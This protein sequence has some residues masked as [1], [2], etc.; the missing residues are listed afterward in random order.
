MLLTLLD[1]AQFLLEIDVERGSSHLFLY[2]EK[3][4]IRK[5]G[6][7]CEKSDDDDGLRILTDQRDFIM[8]KVLKPLV[9]SIRCAKQSE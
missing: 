7:V 5:S 6:C 8:M 9:N 3:S 4:G 1:G 2:D